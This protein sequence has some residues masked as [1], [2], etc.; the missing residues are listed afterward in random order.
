M[1]LHLFD[2]LLPRPVIAHLAVYT[3]RPGMLHDIQQT[4]QTSYHV[5]AV[6][7]TCITSLTI[8]RY[9][10]INS[11]MLVTPLTQC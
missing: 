4:A 3:A 1:T 10:W 11:I 2:S 8:D 6:P 5:K 9:R 7:D